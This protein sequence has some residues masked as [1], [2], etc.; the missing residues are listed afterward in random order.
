MGFYLAVESLKFEF[1]KLFNCSQHS[2]VI[3]FREVCSF[4]LNML[5]L[6]HHQN[7]QELLSGILFGSM[8]PECMEDDSEEGKLRVREIM[9]V[10]TAVNFYLDFIA[11]LECLYFTIQ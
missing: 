6:P 10:I 2:L 4:F 11:V 1:M 7:G 9:T 5:L 3:I 8:L